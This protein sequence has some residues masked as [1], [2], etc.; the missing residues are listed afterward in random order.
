M[1]EGESRLILVRVVRVMWWILF[2]SYFIE[3]TNVE[4]MDL[5]P[6]LRR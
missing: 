2:V 6:S 4:G 5:F 3:N 1:G